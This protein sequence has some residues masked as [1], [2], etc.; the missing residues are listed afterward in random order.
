MEP[1][2]APTLTVVRRRFGIVHIHRK[3]HEVVGSVDHA[4]DRA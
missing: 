1:T 2:H 3:I 4:L